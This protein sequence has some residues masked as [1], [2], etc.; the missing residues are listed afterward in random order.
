M[1]KVIYVLAASLI[2]FA[3]KGKVTE[4]AN[5]D[6]TAVVETTPEQTAQEATAPQPDNAPKSYKATFSPDSATLGKKSEAKIK[7]KEGSG[8]ELSDPEGKSTGVLLTLKFDVTNKNSITEGNSVYLNTSLFRLQ[9]D[10]NTSLSPKNY[11][12]TSAAPESTTN[13]ATAIFEVPPGAKPVKLILFYD[14]TRASVG[15]TY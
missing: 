10:N 15:L 4:N 11:N 8:V 2:L 7:L 3:C 6:S 13:D 9:L 14:D 1:K 5:A 12:T